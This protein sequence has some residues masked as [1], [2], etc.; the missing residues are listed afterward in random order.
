[1]IDKDRAS[2]LLATELG[3]PRLV[4]VTDVERVALGWGTPEQRDLDR[5]S[6]ED[7]AR[8]MAAGEFGVGSMQPKIESAIAF[9][10]SG[11]ERVHITS[12]GKLGEA[13][14]DAGG[15]AIEG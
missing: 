1:V 6:V 9:L 14:D 15:T 12:P 2:S 3:L 7:A 8:Y 5:V 10:R 13:L 11:G 4:I